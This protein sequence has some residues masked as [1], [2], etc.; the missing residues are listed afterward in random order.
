MAHLS[1]AARRLCAACGEQPA[2]IHY[3]ADCSPIVQRVQ[4]DAITALGRAP[5]NHQ[6][7][8]VD[9][10]RGGQCRDH[11]HY[12]KPLAVDWVCRTC[13]KLRGPAFDVAEMVAAYKARD[14]APAPGP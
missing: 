7:K 12:S 1:V 8:C 3:C 5:L 13:N 2:R 11:R 14:S 6:Y 4:K 10:G 9:C